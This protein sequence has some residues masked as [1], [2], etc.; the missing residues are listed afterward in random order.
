MKTEAEFMA[1]FDIAHKEYMELRAAKGFP[2]GKPDRNKPLPSWVLR[3]G[4]RPTMTF[5]T[6]PY[7]GT[8]PAAKSVQKPTVTVKPV[9]AT[10]VKPEASQSFA[11][12]V[13][14]VIADIKPKG[15]TQEQVVEHAVSVLNMKRT[16]AINCVKHNWDRVK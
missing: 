13:R 9:A 11:S 10:V 6:R 14:A 5:V 2:F 1:E 8:V 16:S 3:A 7:T 15:W 12:Q 4:E